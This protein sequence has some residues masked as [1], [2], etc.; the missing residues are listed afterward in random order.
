MGNSLHDKIYLGRAT[1]LHSGRVQL[2]L[3]FG[4]CAGLGLAWLAV[5][6]FR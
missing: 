6:T 1:G 5:R 3:A 2:A 4:V